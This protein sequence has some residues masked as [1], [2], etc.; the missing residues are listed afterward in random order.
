[1]R[2][3]AEVLLL[4]VGILLAFSIDAW[5]EHRQQR[6][7]ET[8]LI[9]AVAQEV[10]D[11]RTSLQDIL[12]QLERGSQGHDRFLQATPEELATVQADSIPEWLA[13]LTIPWTYD[14]SLAA[15]AA[16]LQTP[17]LDSGVDLDVRML[18]GRWV[19]GIEDSREEGAV[20]MD[21]GR[22]AMSRLAEY[23]AANDGQRLRSGIGPSFYL[24]PADLARLRTDRAFVAVTMDFRMWQGVYGLE[25]QAA[26]SVLDS[27]AVL[28]DAR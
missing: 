4:V 9:D 27:L 28:L 11:N 6:Q 20:A 22:A 15:A 19:R 3:G 8:S 5:W 10:A 23:V 18:L 12:D 14:P 25:I 21:L 7:V 26:G 24:S 17:P 16:L 2:R 13:A 1:M